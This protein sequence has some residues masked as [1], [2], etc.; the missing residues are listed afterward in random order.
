MVKRWAASGVLNGE[1]S[2]KRIK[3]CTDMPTLVGDF[4]RHF[5]IVAPMCVA[6]EVA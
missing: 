3:G 5:A 6:K 4:A 2:F 1:R